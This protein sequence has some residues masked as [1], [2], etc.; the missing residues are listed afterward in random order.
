MLVTARYVRK[1]KVV[2]SESEVMRDYGDVKRLFL[3]TNS[4]S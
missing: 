2:V 4:N 3:G 1:D